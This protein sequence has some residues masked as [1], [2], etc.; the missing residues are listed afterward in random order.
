MVRTPLAAFF[1]SPLMNALDGDSE[2]HDPDMSVL[3]LNHEFD[4]S[5]QMYPVFLRT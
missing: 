5:K 1:N 4:T 3:F 2:V